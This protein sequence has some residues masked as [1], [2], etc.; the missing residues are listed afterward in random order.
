[1]SLTV[2][3]NTLT[4]EAFILTDFVAKRLRIDRRARNFHLLQKLL[5]GTRAPHSYMFRD[6]HTRSEIPITGMP[7]SVHGGK[8]IDI[9]I[10]IAPGDSLK[11]K[12]PGS[13]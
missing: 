10:Q 2:R 5:S 13:A 6:W 3:P 4:A 9:F 7:T 12:T 8:N 1:M 11:R